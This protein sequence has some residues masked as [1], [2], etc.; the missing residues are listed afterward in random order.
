MNKAYDVVVIGGGAVGTACAYYLSKNG[1]KTALLEKQDFSS[2]TS[3]RCEGHLAVHDSEAGSFSQISKY[4]LDLFENEVIKDLDLDVHYETMGIGLLC[5]NENEIELVKQIMEGKKKEGIPIRFLDKYELRQEEPNIADDILG[6]AIYEC[7]S[8]LSPM[9]LC[10]AFSEKAKKYGADIYNY[11]EVKDIV[12][13]SNNS[14]EKVIT[15]RGEFIT[16]NVVNAAG[17]WANS[18][19]D[20]VGL[21]IPV[22]PRQGQILITEKTP[23]NVA[24]RSYSEVGY[25]AAK[26]GKKRAS[27][28]EDMEKYGVALV[29]EKTMDENYLLGSSRVFCGYN[30]KTNIEI[31]QAIAQRAMRFFPVLKDINIIRSYAGLRPATPDGYPIVSKTDI[32]G[33]YIAAGHEG[34]G[35]SLAPFTGKSI[36]SLIM[37]TEPEMDL[38]LLDINRFK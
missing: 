21:N 35:I 37:G 14:V 19:G 25:L 32:K 29:I 26:K 34:N 10:Y 22:K 4:S 38:I 8:K 36:V 13:D 2:G 6:A 7:D 12:V 24:K 9:H 15:D 17:V 30:T 31:M 23:I 11:T 5:E 27:V 3:C 28:T 18:I 33:F 20:M 16:K 1:L